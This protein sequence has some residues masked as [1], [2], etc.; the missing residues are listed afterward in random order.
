LTT[1]FVEIITYYFITCC[2]W[3]TYC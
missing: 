1:I 3:C 2:G